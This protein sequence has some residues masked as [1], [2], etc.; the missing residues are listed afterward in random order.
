MS[1]A[2][3]TVVSAR[4][5]V[6]STAEMASSALSRVRV[7][8]SMA[9]SALACVR[10]GD[11]RDGVVGP[12]LRAGDARD[13]VVR[14]GLRARDALDRPV[15]HQPRRGDVVDRGVHTVDDLLDPVDSTRR[16]S[17]QLLHL[18]DRRSHA[19]NEGEG[20]GDAVP[21][22]LHGGE[23]VGRSWQRRESHPSQATHGDGG[24]L[25]GCVRRSP[26]QGPPPA[27]PAW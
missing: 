16:P 25:F 11:A 21:E 20:V 19:R 17:E 27:R 8:A 1:S 22:T 3:L 6:F 14:L 9:S 15:G 4:A 18:P 26:S 5:A 24:P 13:G 12:G 10:A 2:R 23:D 7:T